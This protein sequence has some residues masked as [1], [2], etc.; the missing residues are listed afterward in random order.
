MKKTFA[1]ITLALTFLLFIHIS[2]IVNRKVKYQKDLKQSYKEMPAFAF[3]TSYDTLFKSSSIKSGPVLIIYFHPDCEHCQYEIS[4]IFNSPL[5]RSDIWILLVTSADSLSTARFQ[6][7]YNIMYSD[8]LKMLYDENFQF[9]R[10]FDKSVIPTSIIYRRDLELVK[11][12]QGEV[13]PNQILK[14]LVGED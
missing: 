4:E 10:I 12:F 2:I 7:Q 6:Q 9:E 8:K 11:I 5:I 3:K 13:L 1:I 14:T